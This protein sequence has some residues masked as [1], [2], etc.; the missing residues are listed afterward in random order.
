MEQPPGAT[1]RLRATRKVLADIPPPSTAWDS[2]YVL[3]G[4]KRYSF[5]FPGEETEAR[6]C[7]TTARATEHRGRGCPQT[8]PV[9]SLGEHILQALKPEDRGWGR[10]FLKV[11][12]QWRWGAV[13]GDIHPSHQRGLVRACPEGFLAEEARWGGGGGGE[14]GEAG[15]WGGGG[16][17]TAHF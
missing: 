1:G 8:G 10:H 9:Q 13:R 14:G 6:S 16:A 7:K 17:G 15:G 5:P 4:S 12:P 11:C 3:W 2:P